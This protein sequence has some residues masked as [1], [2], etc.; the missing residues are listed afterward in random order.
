MGILDSLEFHMVKELL[1]SDSYRPYT[2]Y[3]HKPDTAVHKCHTFVPTCTNQIS[4]ILFNQDAK[5]MM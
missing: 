5:S 4:D 3:Q 1:D 2:I